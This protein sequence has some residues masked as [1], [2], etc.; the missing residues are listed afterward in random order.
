MV[1]SGEGVSF[2]FSNIM[3]FD[4]HIAREI[5]GYDILDNIITGFADSLIEDSTNVYDIGC[6]TGRL[7]HRLATSLENETDESRRRTVQFIGFEPNRNLVNNSLLGSKVRIIQEKV[8]RQT[9]FDNASVIFSIFTL[10]FI[11]VNERQ[12]VL[13]Q[14]YKGLNMNGA[15]IWAEKVY[16]SDPQ[17]ES[18]ITKQHLAFKR[19]GS[20]AE[21]IL[22]K[23]QRLQAIMRPLQLSRDIQMLKRAGFERYEIFWRVNNFMALVAI[24]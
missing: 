18:L 4:Q 21:D 23:D 8:T 5:R 10:Q 13:R 12:R 7:I 14:V 17:I 20:S 19:E 9:T 16:S 15:F 2:S 11:P 6:S 24:K 3:N 1:G 22:N